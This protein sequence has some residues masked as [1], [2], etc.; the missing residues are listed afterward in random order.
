VGSEPIVL[1][2]FSDI[3]EIIGSSA[4]GI[5]NVRKLLSNSSPERNWLLV[6]D[7]ADDLYTDYQKYIPIGN[8][9]AIIMTS[10]VRKYNIH[11]NTRS[12]EINSL[13]ERDYVSFF[14]KGVGISEISQSGYIQVAKNVINVIQ[15]YILALL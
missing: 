12:E 6:L 2:E 7:N 4:K 5:D 13:A 11:G 9:N 8:Y 10:R 3:A 1:V 14:L 15:S